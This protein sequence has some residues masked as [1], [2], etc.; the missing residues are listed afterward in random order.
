MIER[1]NR[2][3]ELRGLRRSI[4]E[5]DAE[6]AKLSRNEFERKVNAAEDAHARAVSDAVTR[7][8]AALDAL[9]SEPATPLN[10]A[11]MS[12]VHGMVDHEIGER[13]RE[14]D[15]AGEALGEAESELAEKRDV[16]AQ[17]LKREEAAEG[18]VERWEEAN[19]HLLDADEDDPDA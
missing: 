19:R 18:A 12:N 8:R 9:A 2:L 14:A 3:R 16:L 15:E 6:R 10:V 11:R 17:F 4:A 5:K 13:R 1:M 7:R